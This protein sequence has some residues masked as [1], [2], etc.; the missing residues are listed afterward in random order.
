MIPESAGAFASAVMKVMK[1]T[2]SEGV[3][4]RSSPTLPSSPR[5]LFSSLPFVPHPIHLLERRVIRRSALFAQ[6]LFDVAEATFELCVRCAQRGFRI[7]VEITT[8]I[9]DAKQHI[10]QLS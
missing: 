2:E 8:H 3:S 7:D 10:A 4:G 5:S 1:V 6:T 9:D